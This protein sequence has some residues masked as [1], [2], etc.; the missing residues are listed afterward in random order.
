MS[1]KYPYIYA[2]FFVVGLSL[3]TSSLAS[4]AETEESEPATKNEEPS[5]SDEAD[6]DAEAEPQ[7]PSINASWEFARA[8]QLATAGGF[9]RAIPHYENALKAAP[10]RFTQ[11]YYNLAEMH[12]LKKQCDKSVLLY[13]VYL[14]RESDEDNLE[15]ARKA[16]AECLQGKDTG[17]LS[18]KL[19]PT[20]L[21]ELRINGYL[22]DTD[23]GAQQLKLLPGEYSLQ[24]S[25]PEYITQETTIT[26]EADK[27][28]ERVLALE[29]M[30]FHGTLKLNISQE[31][32][33][34]KIQPK[35]LDSKRADARPHEFNSPMEDPLK[36]GTGTYF[37]EVT[38]PGHKRW[39]RNV[40]IT[41]DNLSEIDIQLTPQ[42]PEAIRRD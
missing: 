29:K 17:T 40:N 4:A 35:T 12:R 13:S 21:T 7:E 41:R 38:S 11:A 24:A 9:T 6:S 30:L 23:S 2:L 8:N 36:L 3:T 25:A 33:A 39:I 14:H 22:V 31:N 5:A 18:I 16:R 37:I 42:L 28:V 19:E 20:G 1:V 15:D 32:A 27:E 34:I 26:V 10:E